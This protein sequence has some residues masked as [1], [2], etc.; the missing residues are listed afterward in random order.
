MG[1]YQRPKLAF[2][3][4][5]G[6]FRG[7]DF[8]ERFLFFGFVFAGGAAF[9]TALIVG[10]LHLGGDDEHGAPSPAGFIPF[11]DYIGGRGEFV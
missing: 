4:L 7:E 3:G 2:G 10:L 9:V 1:A 11:N 5:L 8:I 6:H